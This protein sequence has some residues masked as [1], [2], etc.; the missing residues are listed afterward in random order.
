MADSSNETRRRGLSREAIVNRALELGQAE[1]LEGVS[2]RRLATDLGV[3]PMALYRHVRDKQDLVNA[4]TEVVLDGLDLTIGFK[5]SLS[6][7]DK[8]RRALTNFKQQIQER[9]LALPLSIAYSGEG[10]LSFW[11]TN[12][13]LLGILLDAGFKRRQA[14]VLIRAVSN[15]VSGY[16]L[17]MGQGGPEVWEE[18]LRDP[19]QIKLLRKRFELTQLGLPRDQF[20]HSVESAKEFADVWLSDPNLWWAD[21]VDLLIFGLEGLLQRSSQGRRR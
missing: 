3:T 10:P 16:L 9:P 1:G 8:L 13:V 15:L 5:P 2:L 18:Q 17:L 20:P 21:T 7:Q 4:M 6:W 12:E 19:Q 11:R 14:V